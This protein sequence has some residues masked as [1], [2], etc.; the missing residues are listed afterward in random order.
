MARIYKRKDIYYLDYFVNGKRI[1]ERHGRS[2]KAAERDKSIIEGK[3][4]SSQFVSIPQD[5]PLSTLY[6][7]FTQHVRARRSINT[8]KRYRAILQNF[9]QFLKQYPYLL[10]ISQ[11]T[12]NC[13]V[14]GSF[15][16][17]VSTAW[18]IARREFRGRRAVIWLMVLPLLTNGMRQSSTA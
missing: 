1:R 6:H 14:L 11:L 8:Q 4:A 13:F 15:V 9:E 5:K 2:K 7:D 17:G 16:L 10:K 18:L 12:T 3:L